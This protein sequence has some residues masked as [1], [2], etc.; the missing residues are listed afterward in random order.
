MEPLARIERNTRRLVWIAGIALLTGT[1][2]GAGIAGMLHMRL[3]PTERKVKL[4]LEAQHLD[5]K[6]HLMEHPELEK[7]LGPIIRRI[8]KLSEEKEPDADN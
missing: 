6:L 5:L 4:L 3:S 8:N 1:C 7:D 2:I